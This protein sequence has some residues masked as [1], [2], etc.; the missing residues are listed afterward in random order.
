[1]NQKIE[2]TVINGGDL[3]ATQLAKNLKHDLQ[4]VAALS[5]EMLNDEE[6]FN[7][8][9]K[10]YWTRYQAMQ[11]EVNDKSKEETFAPPGPSKEE[12]RHIDEVLNQ[13]P[14]ED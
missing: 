11:K 4:M 6:I 1:M 14:N 5:Y 10:V 2:K 12:L 3:S 13:I 8:I 7:A 9:L